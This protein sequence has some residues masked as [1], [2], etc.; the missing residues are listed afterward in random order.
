M[1]VGYMKIQPSIATQVH[2]SGVCTFKTNLCWYTYNMYCGT[3]ECSRDLWNLRR[4]SKLLGCWKPVCLR[5]VAAHIV[6]FFLFSSPQHEVLTVCCCYKP[7]S[8]VRQHFLLTRA[9]SA[10]E[11]LLWW[12]IVRACVYAST[13]SFNK[14]SSETAHWILIKLHRND[15]LSKLSKPFQLVA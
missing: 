13:I 7:L 2:V 1:C 15:H 11:E 12:P 3:L 10:Q 5:C 14:F 6:I 9:Q 8:V 4:R